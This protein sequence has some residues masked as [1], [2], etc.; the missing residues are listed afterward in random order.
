MELYKK[1]KMFLLL[2]NDLNTEFVFIFILQLTTIFTYKCFKQFKI[3]RFLYYCMSKQ[4]VVFMGTNGIYESCKRIK[5][6]TL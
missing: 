5:R 3:H 6:K 2:N 4:Q 1:K